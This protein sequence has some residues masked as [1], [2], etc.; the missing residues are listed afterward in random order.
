MNIDKIIYDKFIPLLDKET[1]N[2]ISLLNHSLYGTLIDEDYTFDF[3]KIANIVRD[4]LDNIPDINN[5][6]Y[7]DSFDEYW[8]VDKN[9]NLINDEWSLDLDEWQIEHTYEIQPEEIL[10]TIL[11]YELYDTIY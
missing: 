6:S 1:I 8:Y 10:K 3:S 7:Y 4:K 11:G 2:N 5:N 9:D